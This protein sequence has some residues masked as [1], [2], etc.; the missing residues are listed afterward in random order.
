MILMGRN[1]TDQGA[2]FYCA[3]VLLASPMGG[4]AKRMLRNFAV[5]RPRTQKRRDEEAA[6][7]GQKLCGCAGTRLRMAAIRLSSGRE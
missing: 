1:V 4:Y 2:A 6:R 5:R 3:W 7:W